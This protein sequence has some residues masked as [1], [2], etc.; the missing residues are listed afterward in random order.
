MDFAR[1][2]VRALG[3]LVVCVFVA[4]PSGAG[5]DEPVRALFVASGL[6][7]EDEALLR[8][9][10][11]R[12]LELE[13]LD[14]DGA[15]A[16]LSR[17]ARR[18]PEDPTEQRVETAEREA[19]SAYLHLRFGPAETSFSE[20]ITAFTEQRRRTPDASM[21][22]RLLFGRALV[23]L[24][25]RRDGDARADLALA[26]ALDPEL[27]P[28]PAEYG[29]PIFRAISAARAE[30][31]RARRVELRVDVAPEDSVVRVDGAPVPSGEVVR[32]A[33][34]TRHLVTV[35]RLGYVPQ[36]VWVDAPR[37]GER[38]EQLVLERAQGPLL[39]WQALQAWRA[40]SG[41]EELRVASMPAEVMPLVAQ[42]LS[43]TRVVS[44]SRVSASEIAVVLRDAEGGEVVRQAS[45]GRVDWEPTPY[46]VL[47][48]ALEG[49]VLRPPPPSDVTLTVAAP[50][51][52]APAETIPFRVTVR[53]AEERVERVTARCGTLRTAT[54]LG[55]DRDGDALA[56]ALT[57]PDS[58]TTL[59]CDVRAL[60]TDGR[61]LASSPEELIVEVVESAGAS[62]WYSLWYVWGAVGLAVV[63][64]ITAGVLATRDDGPPE[65][66]LRIYGP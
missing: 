36:T 56:L 35:E 66:F 45:G 51:R 32:V 23:R 34:G 58:E 62:P 13:L 50:S 38:R 39:A 20:A 40:D 4:S 59:R 8:D 15:V 11:A 57:A 61:A 22:S 41:E 53:D 64:G 10:I 65:Q 37:R 31:R 9:A 21:L 46:A 26:L 47:A 16:R 29:P 18:L 54:R 52:V 2:G 6:P 14:A 44:A 17:T 43:A 27:S 24:A 30:S 25:A 33:G 60:D 49:R 1:I 12:E 63:A 48:A 42:S 7:S 28:D 5:A 19:L 55:R 3:L